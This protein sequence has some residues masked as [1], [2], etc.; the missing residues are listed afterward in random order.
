[1]DDFKS[2]LLEVI[3][4]FVIAMLLF[5]G[6]VRG[7]TIVFDNVPITVTVRGEKVFEGKSYMVDVVS[8]GDTTKVTIF[9]G[10]MWLIPQAYYVGKDIVITGT[11]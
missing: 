4:P 7:V 6:V 3:L 8:T 11:K 9:G 2:F 1:M 5:I 10:F